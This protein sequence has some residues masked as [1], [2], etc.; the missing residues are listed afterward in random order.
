MN[1]PRSQQSLFVPALFAQVD[2]IIFHHLWQ[3]FFNFP[4]CT[5]G[6][7]QL[8]GLVHVLLQ[9][10]QKTASRLRACGSD[11]TNGRNDLQTGYNWV[12]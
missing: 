4:A 1:Q 3:R 9:K 8:T 6:I 10:L 12:D 11:A 7:A 5:K 2:P